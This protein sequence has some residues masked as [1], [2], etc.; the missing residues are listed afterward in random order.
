MY[1]AF[2]SPGESREEEKYLKIW[3]I[4][5][6]SLGWKVSALKE[7]KRDD[8]TDIP[9]RL[10]YSLLSI[11]NNAYIRIGMDVCCLSLVLLVSLTPPSMMIYTTAPCLSFYF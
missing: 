11:H 5:V 8:A 3:N 6:S 2:L 9:C 1:K 4:N 10:L 7:T